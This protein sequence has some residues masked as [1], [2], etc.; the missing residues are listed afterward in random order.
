MSP[1]CPVLLVDDHAMIRTGLKALIRRSGRFA[2][3]GEACSCQEARQLFTMRQ[4]C[5]VIMDI[6]LGKESGLDLA[7]EFITLAPETGILMYT[8]H[9]D[10]DMVTKAFQSG[11]R[12][13]VAK[14][15]SV[16][17]VL[18][19]LDAVFQGK[20]YVDDNLMGGLLDK[21]NTAH[22][23]DTDNRDHHE[24]LTP[25][26]LEVLSLVANGMSSKDI[27]QRLFISPKTVENHRTSIMSKLG[28]SNAVDMARYAIRHGLSHLDD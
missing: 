9:T 26:E 21:L 10:V 3:V 25:R 4:P 28:L 27:S 15:S 11:V 16:E 8:M 19:A 7:R 13:Y 18:L 6:S 12:G 20:R 2:V 23:Q 17:K 5:L 24:S 22:A 1:C 14:A